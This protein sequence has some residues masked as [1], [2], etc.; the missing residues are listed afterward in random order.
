LAALVVPALLL[1]L[2][3]ASV[4]ATPPAPGSLDASFGAG[5]KVT[6][7]ID[8]YDYPTAVAVQ[9]DRKV[10]VADVTGTGS[11]LLRYNVDGSLDA[12]F[13]SGGTTTTPIAGWAAVALQRDGRIVVAGSEFDG[14]GNVF[15]LA[16]FRPDGTP[17]TSFGSTGTVTTAIGGFDDV[18]L[19]VGIQ[20]GQGGAPD[21]IVVAGASGNGTD[22]DFAAA[23]YLSDGRLDPAFG[24]GGKVTTAM[25]AGDEFATGVAVDTSGRVL[26]AGA[27]FTDPHFLLA[28]YTTDGTLDAGFGAGGKVVT[29]TIGDVEGLDYANSVALQPDGRIVVGGE[30]ASDFALAR[31]NTDGSLDRGFGS[32]G[33]VSTRVAAGGAGF[34]VA[35][36][37]DARIVLA[38]F[39][40][41]R[42]TQDSGYDLNF[43]VARYNRDG[44]LDTGFGA[45]GSVTTA[46]GAWGYDSAYAVAIE[47]D[48]HIVAAGL[49]FPT[50]DNYDVA[51]VRYNGGPGTPTPP[52]PPAGPRVAL[53][54]RPLARPPL[55]GS[56]AALLKR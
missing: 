52:Q 54:I 46:I 17:D 51:V 30:S 15:A 37:S 19:A 31:Y 33:T 12:G 53:P 1:S 32:G 20:S 21:R 4:L 27:S 35:V 55:F 18:A 48:G 14:T 13:G 6:T 22:Y 7:D 11:V 38:G 47:P 8:R 40:F 36:Q 44:S 34:A 39:A 41:V 50:Y 49:S 28:R 26:V 45:G 23:R 3:A 29:P 56:P 5:G 42:R 24:A 43:A 10:I 2:P 25:G 16:R 9:P